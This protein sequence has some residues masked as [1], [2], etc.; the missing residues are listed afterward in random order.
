MLIEYPAAPACGRFLLCANFRHVR[1]IPW[2]LGRWRAR[3]RID[4]GYVGRLYGREHARGHVQP[5]CR[6]G[7]GVGRRKGCCHRWRSGGGPP[8]SCNAYGRGRLTAAQRTCARPA[9]RTGGQ[10]GLKTARRGACSRTGRWRQQPPTRRRHRSRRAGTITRESSWALR[11]PEVGRR[12]QRG[13]V[14]G[15]GGGRGPVTPV[16]GQF[17]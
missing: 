1:A 7:G 13:A 16:A 6:G 15:G 3:R 12:A 11:A 2:P 17:F 10:M 14:G 5:R 9:R 8:A 4:T